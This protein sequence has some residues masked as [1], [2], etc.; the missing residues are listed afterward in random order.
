MPVL[1]GEPWMIGRNP[2][3][4]ELH[5]GEQEVVDHAIFQSDDGRWHLWACI[6]GDRES[7][8]SSTDGRAAPWIR[9]TGSPGAS[10]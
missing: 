8:A 3:L 7:D 2:D 4:G 6:R 1:D 5:D 10:P 9:R